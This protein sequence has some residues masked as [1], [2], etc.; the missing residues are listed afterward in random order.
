MFLWCLFFDPHQ[1][2]KGV[3]S[4]SKKTQIVLL[5]ETINIGKNE[6]WFGEGKQGLERDTRS[7]T[8]HIFMYTLVSNM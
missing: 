3:N 8:Q 2:S 4:N 6:N 5:F 7:I 1:T